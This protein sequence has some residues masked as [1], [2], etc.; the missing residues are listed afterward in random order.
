MA[1]QTCPV[2]CCGQIPSEGDPHFHVQM[3]V[4]FLYKASLQKGDLRLSGLP[5]GQS[6]GGGARTRGRR[7]P[8]DLGADS[9]ATVPPTPCPNEK[10]AS[11][12]D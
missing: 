11:R 1:K 3:K 5:S 10:L 4:W 2:M 8:A 6:A 12:L 9:P 7:V